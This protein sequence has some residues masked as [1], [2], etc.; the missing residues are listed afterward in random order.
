M[1]HVN[2]KTSLAN[3]LVSAL[4]YLATTWVCVWLLKHRLLDAPVV[5]RALVSLMPV[6]PI[7]FA[8]GAVVSLVRGGDE[9]QRRIDLEAL[10]IAAVAIGLGCLTL[11]FLLLAHVLDLSAREA[12]LWVFPAQWIA[13]GLARIWAQRRYR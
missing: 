3:C 12:L 11:S 2:R 5:V 6:I 9:L 10:A 8:I 7:G 4:A 13:Y 1:K